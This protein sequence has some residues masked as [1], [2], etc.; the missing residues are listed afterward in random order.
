MTVNQP[1]EL[2]ITYTTVDNEC[3]GDATGI[4]ETLVTGGTPGYSY[5]WPNQQETPGLTGLPAG[6]YQLTI[7]D[8]SDCVKEIPIEITQPDALYAD[9]TVA[10]VTCYGDRNGTIFA[11]PQGGVPPYRFSLNNSDYFGSST[12]IGLTAGHY[13]VFMKD[14]NDCMFITDAVISEPDDFMVDAGPDVTINLGQTIQIEATSENGVGE[15]MY[16]WYPP[17]DSTM[18]CVECIAPFFFPQS[19]I[20][21]E[22]YGVD[23]NGCE[24]TDLLTIN[25]AKPRSA[26]VPTGFT[27]NGDGVNDIL[28]VHGLPGTIVRTF[29]VYD[30]WGELLL[31]PTISK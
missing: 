16:V 25:V 30:R 15:V 4:I 29:R 23:E 17:Y 7:T 19:T 1:T 3:Y 8:G 13:N 5:A 6:I 26:V 24:D 20:I 2:R 9:I 14:A 11:A 31:K 10:D 18:S 12:L 27:P 22:L 28:Q 21:Y